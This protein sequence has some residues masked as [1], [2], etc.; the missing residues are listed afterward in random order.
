MIG[1]LVKI[2]VGTP[3]GLDLN[4]LAIDEVCA[5]A[6]PVFAGIFAQRRL[7]DQLLEHIFYTALLGERL[8]RDGWI[9]LAYLV[10]R[11]A[12]RATEIACA[13][14]GIT[15]NCHPIAT[16]DPA[17]HRVVRHVRARKGEGDQAKEGKGDAESDLGFEE[18]A[19][20]LDHYRAFQEFENLPLGE[21]ALLGALYRACAA[22]AT[23]RE[24]CL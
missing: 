4:D 24:S 2:A 11:I 1:L 21:E 19:E 15:D 16:C 7:I 23:V 18:P 20:V 12:C 3:E 22:A 14:L 5:S 17:E 10:D 9:L 8:D 6:K 13:D